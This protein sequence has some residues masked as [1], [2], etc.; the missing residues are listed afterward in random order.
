MFHSWR[1]FLIETFLSTKLPFLRYNECNFYTNKKACL[2]SCKKKLFIVVFFLQ[3]LLINPEKEQK[4][5]LLRIKFVKNSGYNCY[6]WELKL[7]EENKQ[8]IILTK[9]NDNNHNNN[10]SQ[11]YICRNWKVYNPP[12]NLIWQWCEPLDLVN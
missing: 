11:V 4:L 6:Y 1:N 10:T 9:F 8:W 5:L 2:G 7:T 3:K 12:E